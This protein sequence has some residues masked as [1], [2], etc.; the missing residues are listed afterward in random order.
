[1]SY[2]NLFVKM[3]VVIGTGGVL[4]VRENVPYF[5]LMPSKVLL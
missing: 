3:E 2:L 4:R 1:M 5:C